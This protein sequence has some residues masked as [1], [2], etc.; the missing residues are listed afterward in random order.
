[1]GRNRGLPIARAAELPKTGHAREEAWD[2]TPG[3]R[4]S[5][6]TMRLLCKVIIRGRTLTKKDNI[7]FDDFMGRPLY[8]LLFSP[9]LFNHSS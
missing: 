7:F 5:I 9:L 4:E 8:L 2:V 1:M 6:P 3:V